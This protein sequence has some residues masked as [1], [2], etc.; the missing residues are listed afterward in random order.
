MMISAVGSCN[1]LSFITHFD[2]DDSWCETPSDGM[3][4]SDRRSLSLPE[5]DLI[6]RVYAANPR[7]IVVLLADFPYR[8]N[9]TN[10]HVPAIPTISQNAQEIG[11]ALADVVVGD[12][13]PAGRT[14]VTGRSRSIS[15]PRCSTTTFTMGT[16]TCTATANR[17]IHSATVSPTRPLRT[18]TCAPQRHPTDEKARHDHSHSR[19]GKYGRTRW[20]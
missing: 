20:R 9:W 12:Y 6:R 10:E 5:E 8:I 17:F 16:P 13:N 18:P 15:Y 1:R 11:T 19:S 2:S 14:V 4:N 7:T 3:E